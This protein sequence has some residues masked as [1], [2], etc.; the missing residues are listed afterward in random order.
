M[1]TK[2]PP[3]YFPVMK[4]KRQTLPSPMAHPAEPA[5]SQVVSQVAH[6]EVENLFQTYYLSYSSAGYTCISGSYTAQRYVYFKFYLVYHLSLHF[7]VRCW[8]YQHYY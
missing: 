4:G 2:A 5:E 1:I 7:V 3:P 6:V 8:Y